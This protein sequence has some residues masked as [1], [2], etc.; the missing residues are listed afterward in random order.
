MSRALDQVVVPNAGAAF[1]TLKPWDERTEPA[2]QV[3][4]ILGSLAG[5]LGVIQEAVAFPFNPPPIQGLGAAG[6]TRLGSRRAGSP[7]SP[8]IWRAPW[9]RRRARSC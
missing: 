5:H 4:A 1:V 7:M 2:E 9:P 8:T 3:G 6:G